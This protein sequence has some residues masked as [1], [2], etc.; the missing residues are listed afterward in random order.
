MNKYRNINYS[1]FPSYV[2]NFLQYR[3]YIK[4]LSQF[5]VYGEAERL[6]SFFKYVICFKDK[7]I[8][9]SHFREIHDFTSLRIFD[10]KHFTLNQMLSYLEFITNT[11]NYEDQYKSNVVLTIRTFYSY[12]HN[13]LHLLKEN[14]FKDLAIPKYRLKTVVYMSFEECQKYLSVIDNIRDKAII[15]LILN[16]GARRCEVANALLD[17]LDLKNKILLVTGKG[18]KE[19]FLYLNNTVVNLLQQYLSTRHDNCNYLFTSFHNNKLD[20]N[21]IYRIVRKYIEKA[22]L[23]V[24]KFSTHKLRHTFAT[25]LY[26]NG[27]DVR[28]LQELLGHSNL[29]TTMRYTHLKNNAL[30][31][32]VENYVL[33]KKIF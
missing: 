9:L 26:Q 18:N 14:Q 2:V 5:T 23:D 7:N 20:Y 10:L 27:T 4:N 25:L 30:L 17:N 19:R 21:D 16:T 11:L 31:D 22:G 3:L 13:E 33:N 15:E 6:K 24:T 29:D 12:L 1:V 8:E 28:Q 32:T